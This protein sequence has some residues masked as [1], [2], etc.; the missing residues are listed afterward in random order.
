VAEPTGDR[1]PGWDAVLRKLLILVA[2]VLIVLSFLPALPTN[3]GF[4]RMA[5]VPRAQLLVATLAVFV[6]LAWLARRRNVAT[7]VALVG[8]AGAA[9][10]HGIHLGSVS[11]RA[12]LTEDAATCA[13]SFTVLVANVQR[14]NRQAGDLI[15]MVRAARPAV[16]IAQE[17]DEWWDR[18]LSALADLLPHTEAAITG[19]F[20]GMHLFSRHPL[21]A[22]DVLYPTDPDTPVIRARIEL[23]SGPVNVLGVHPRPPLWSQPPIARDGALLWAALDVA[24]DEPTVLIGDLNAVPWED[25]VRRARRIAGLLDP[26]ES[27]GFLATFDARSAWMRWPLDQIL[28]TA[29]LSTLRAEVLPPF[30]SDHHPYLVELCP[31][32]SGEAAPAPRPGDRAEAEE[33]IAKAQAR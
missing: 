21:A 19:S 25:T 4:V 11:L 30:G 5:G 26:R 2:A 14:G 1:N 16:F 27:E 9:V 17:T 13:Q 28:H 33:A 31:A 22:S 3:I 12:A 18:E 20:Y 32:P 15:A 8:L 24:R 23:P 6:P 10:N 7:L 29:S